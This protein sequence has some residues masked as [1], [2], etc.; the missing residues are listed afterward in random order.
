MCEHAPLPCT[1]YALA[2]GDEY[3]A[4]GTISSKAN[5][6]IGTSQFAL[7]GTPQGHMYFFLFQYMFAASAATIVS[8]AVAERLRFEAYLGYTSFM[9]LWF[10]VGIMMLLAANTMSGQPFVYEYSAFEHK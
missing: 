2:F 6:F 5:G 3:D 4:D 1:G 7:S 9:C 10:V 8:G